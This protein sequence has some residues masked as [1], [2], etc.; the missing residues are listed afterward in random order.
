MP[1]WAGDNHPVGE[2]LVT[3]V[4]ALLFTEVV[5]TALVGSLG[6]AG[7][8]T[9][10]REVAGGLSSV[11]TKPLAVMFPPACSQAAVLALSGVT[12]PFVSRTLCEMPTGLVSAAAPPGFLEARFDN[13]GLTE[14]TSELWWVQTKTPGSP[15]AR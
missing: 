1:L 2:L 3:W 4:I 11:W 12:S 6:P 9:W 8:P 10:T 15:V 13:L 7:L 14:V 5:A